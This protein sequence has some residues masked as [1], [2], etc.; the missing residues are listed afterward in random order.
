[1]LCLTLV[2]T[3]A[4]SLQTLFLPFTVPYNC[5]LKDGHEALGKGKEGKQAFSNAVARGG[6]R[7]KRSASR[8]GFQLFMSLAP[9]L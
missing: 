8:D 1:M 4:Q 2:L 7:G 6:G 9:G 5:P 3:L